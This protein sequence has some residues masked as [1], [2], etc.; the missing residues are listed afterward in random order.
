MLQ[1]WEAM[2]L[3]KDA[4]VGSEACSQAA[5]DRLHTFPHALTSTSTLHT[6]V[7][8]LHPAPH[9]PHTHTQT[10]YTRSL[11]SWSAASGW[12]KRQQR[13]AAQQTRC[14]ASSPSPALAVAW[15]QAHPLPLPMALQL[16]PASALLLAAPLRTGRRVLP[17]SAATQQA[18]AAW[19]AACVWLR[20][21]PAAT[22]TSSSSMRAVRGPGR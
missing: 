8:C 13:R 21:Q 11:H 1:A 22:A 20:P 15:P 18:V 17:A 9:H 16:R 5:S 3:G 2:R 4:Q 10:A 19:T 7:C 6:R 14:A 12:R